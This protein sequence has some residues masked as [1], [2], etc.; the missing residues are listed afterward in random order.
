MF[1]VML[2]KFQR[3][4]EIFCSDSAAY[5]RYASTVY[6]PEK[7]VSPLKIDN[8]QH[9]VTF[10]QSREN[11]RCDDSKINWHLTGRYFYEYHEHPE[12]T[13]TFS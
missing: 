3:E 7:Y 2:K 12:K 4:C 1:E 5:I 8:F 11:E 6:L 13:R 9:I 10:F